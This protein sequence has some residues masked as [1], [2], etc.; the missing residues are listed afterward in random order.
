MSPSSFRVRRATLD[1]VGPLMA[2]WQT[3]HFNADELARRV[4]EFQVAENAEGHLLG[5]LGLQIADR[6]GLIHS[7]G[8]TDFAF[9]EH[10]R[11]LLWDRMRAL[12]ANQGLL[13]LWT[14]EGAPFWHHCGLVKPDAEAMEKLPSLWRGPSSGWL[15]IKLRDDIDALLSADAEFALFMRG[16]KERT[17]RAMQRGKTLKAIATLIA[18]ILFGLALA[19]LFYVVSRHS[20]FLRR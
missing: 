11:P 17:A 5:A 14:R 8:F 12:A 10:L 9:A 15:T 13:R 18:V 2:L 16:E 3:M 4:T 1:D 6:Q 7:E 20:Q 19:G